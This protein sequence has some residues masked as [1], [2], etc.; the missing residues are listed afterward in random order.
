MQSELMK[1]LNILPI[2]AIALGSAFGMVSCEDETS[3]IGPSLVSGDVSIVVDSIFDLEP[4]SV[5]SPV[6]DARSTS[7]LLGRLDVPEFGSIYSS[8]VA[9]LMCSAVCPIP[10]SIGVD[11]I[12]SMYLTLTVKP[13]NLTGDSIAPQQVKVYALTKQLPSNITNQF[14]PEGYYDAS[15]PLG[16]ANFTLSRAAHTDTAFFN[17]TASHEINVKLPTE[18]AKTIYEKYQTDPSMFAWPSTFAKYFPGIYVES[19][20]GKGCIASISST[21][22]KI[23]FHYKGIKNVTVDGV[24]TPKETDIPLAAGVFAVA[25]EVLN[26]NTISFQPSSELKAKIAEGEAF[27]ATPGGYHL[28]IRIPLREILRRYGAEEANLSVFNGLTLRL[29]V[30]AYAADYGFTL[31][32]ELLLVRVDKLE[33]FLKNNQ[34]PDSKESFWSSRSIITGRYDFS[35]LLNY[36]VEKAKDPDKITDADEEFAVIPVSISTYTTSYGSVIVN[37]C[38]P[39]LTKPCFFKIDKSKAQLRFTF[40]KEI[41][42]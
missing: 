4:E 20:F 18:F 6:F 41:I 37:G 1:F 10:D 8:Y 9:R 36:L 28:K 35:D 11:R 25:P 34:L 24:S 7:N 31:P 30:V 17:K 40:T 21:V 29:P 39:Y 23:F 33:S 26:S 15:N 14:N 3:P 42:K 2:I 5:P 16:V 32:P 22:G 12:D 13:G 38:T 19:S 27:I